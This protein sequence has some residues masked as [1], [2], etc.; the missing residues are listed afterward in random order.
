MADIGSGGEIKYKE[1]KGISRVTCDNLIM[2]DSPHA[3]YNPVS[4]TITFTLK[5]P[6]RDE[7]KVSST[8]HGR[9]RKQ[10][11]KDRKRNKNN[12]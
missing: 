11:K 2:D 10:I 5:Q 3:D 7:N 4:P 1:L 12:R 6:S 8:K 9:S